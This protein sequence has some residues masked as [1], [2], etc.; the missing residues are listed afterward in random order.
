MR[1]PRIGR[2]LFWGARQPL[3][4]ALVRWTFAHA[5]GLLPVRRVAE[6]PRVLAFQHPRPAW[7]FHMLLVPKRAL[8]SLMTLRPGDMPLLQD[9]LRLATTIATQAGPVARD[10]VLLVNGGAYQ[11]VGQLHFHLAAGGADLRYTAA[12]S[13]PPLLDNEGVLVSA[14]QPP[15]RTLHLLLEPRPPLADLAALAERPAALWALIAATQR[16]VRERGLLAA[17]FTLLTPTAAGDPVRFHLVSGERV[18]D[19]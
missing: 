19:A 16:I 8:P 7:P 1:R 2:L 17:G 14:A 11:D 4:H 3:T 18:A 5:A 12:P 6:T 15:Q 10:A 13:V 9:I